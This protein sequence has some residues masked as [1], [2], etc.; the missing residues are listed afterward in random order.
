MNKKVLL[1]DDVEL[2]LELERTFFR[3]EGFDLLVA[4]TG[5]QAFE[6]TLAHKPD[7]VFMDLFMPELNGDDA[8]R[9]IK[10]HPE[11]RTIPVVM[12]TQGGRED[13]LAQ[14]RAAGCDDIVLKPI[15]RHHFLATARKHLGIIERMQPRV[16]ARIHIHFG[17]DLNRLLTNYA[18]NLSTG[19]LFI[20][21][22]D[23]LDIDAMLMLDFSLPDPE[24]SICCK[25]RVAWINDSGEPINPKLPTG[26]GV[27]F[28]DLPVEDIGAIRE[29]IK[30][31]CLH[32]AW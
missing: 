15:N 21:S 14:C 2:F 31:Q 13:E 30:A 8:C 11:T 4:R 16:K 5:K 6:M 3:R 12:V 23:V 25:G 22:D 27:Q 10:E 1:V 19:G 17:P 24:R 26:M 18:V 28:L 32:P 20:E 7:L 29:Y 9:K